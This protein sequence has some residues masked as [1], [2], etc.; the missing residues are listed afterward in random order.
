MAD[1]KLI[2]GNTLDILS[3]GKEKSIQCCITSP[4]Y[5]GL[6]SYLDTEDPS[7]NLEIGLEKSPQEYI[8]NLVKVFREVKRMLRDDGTLWIVIGDSYAGSGGP[9]SQYDGK[10]ASGYKG[11]FKKFDNPNRSVLGIKPKD[12][13]GIPWM[14]AFALREDGWFLRQDIIWHKPAPMPESVKDRCTKAHEYV[15]LLSKSKEYFYDHVAMQ[16]D[17]VTNLENKTLPRGSQGYATASAGNKNNAQRGHINGYGYSNPGK[18]NRRS[19]WSIQ[20]RPYREAHFAVF[21][22][23]LIE[24]MILA[25]TS[26]HGACSKCGNPYKRVS[27]RGSSKEVDPSDINR[28]GTGEADVHRK[29]GGQYQKWLD[30]N[31][32]QTIGW[33]ATCQ[34][35]AKVLPCWVLDPFSGAATTGIAALKNNRRFIGIDLNQEYIEIS[36]KRIQKE[37]YEQ[38]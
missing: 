34:C 35:S 24:P 11:E 27:S 25:G 6:R 5:Y 18:R 2:C 1:Y 33:E 32:L 7:K 38:S 30:E 12:L 9:G 13:I 26:E 20:T 17:A 31:P 10:E 3:K 37:I 16:E 22:E 8:E 21:P 15:F 29:V 28:F 4:P 23:A 14:L 19:V 36:E